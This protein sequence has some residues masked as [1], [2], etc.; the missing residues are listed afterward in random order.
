MSFTGEA[1]AKLL[2]TLRKLSP[3][4]ILGA[5]GTAIGIILVVFG[6][7]LQE[8]YGAGFGVT[9]RG[10]G[11]IFFLGGLGAVLFGES[12]R[13]DAVIGPVRRI[14]ERYVTATANWH[15]PDRIGLSGVVIGLIL[16][17]P[18]LLLQILFGSVFGAIVIAPGIVLFWTGAS[19]LI[20]G[21]FHRRKATPSQKKE[22]KREK[23]RDARR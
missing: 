5:A 4:D 20:Y 7:V 21:R 18:A 12:R 9:I 8:H 15:W 23:D 3:N 1:R 2:A 6:I 22:Q 19:L 17:V 16:F 10:L 14:V 13:R 11:G